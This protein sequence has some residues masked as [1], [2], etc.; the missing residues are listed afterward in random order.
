LES[1]QFSEVGGGKPATQEKVWGAVKAK[2]DT[3]MSMRA[4]VHR[5][6]QSQTPR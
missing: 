4:D 5:L 1:Y 3:A 2:G 6:G